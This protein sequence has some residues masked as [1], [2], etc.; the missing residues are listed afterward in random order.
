MQEKLI[1]RWLDS[2]NERGY[3]AAFLQ[4][5][6][7]EGHA[8]VHSTRHMAIEF[9]KDVV[10]I[11]PEGVPCAFQLKGNPGGRLTLAQFREIKGQIEELVEQPIR[12]PGIPDTPHKCYL[13]TNGEV[14]EEVQRA[15]DDLNLGYQRRGFH[16]N[17][18]LKL[19]SRG[20]LLDWA[21]KYSSTF[22]P[23]SFSIHEKLIRFYNEDGAGPLNL[24]LLSQGLD[25]I[26]K[27]SGEGSRLGTLEFERREISASLFITF[28]VRN[29]VNQKNHTAVASAFAALFVALICGQA[30]HDVDAGRRSGVTLSGEGWILFGHN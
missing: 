14:E 22:W 20:M 21:V 2:I 4:M 3:Q 19:I 24:D 6:A 13:V 5:L 25:E 29:F 15:I 1:E 8:V 10:S 27:I 16:L 23:E 28:A 11:D 26:L 17:S 7:G 30:R 18:R 9:G 12:Y